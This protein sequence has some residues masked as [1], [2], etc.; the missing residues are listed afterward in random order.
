MR[1]YTG[2][3]GSADHLIYHVSQSSQSFGWH[4]NARSYNSAH[5]WRLLSCH[6]IADIIPGVS[7]REYC[8]R[9]CNFDVQWA[10]RKR[11]WDI[12]RVNYRRMGLRFRFDEWHDRISFVDAAC[13]LCTSLADKVGRLGEPYSAQV[14]VRGAY[15]RP[16]PSTSPQRGLRAPL[17]APVFPRWGPS[18]TTSSCRA[19]PT[20]GGRPR[21]QEPAT[22]ASRE[23]VPFS[24]LISRKERATPLQKFS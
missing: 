10:G 9:T 13:A 15:Q 3:C 18:C 23:R 17:K 22:P 24:I 5:S 21:P 11:L 1:S 19:V 2:W 16:H 6:Q 7:E 8:N 20:Q 12:V 4:D 14:Y